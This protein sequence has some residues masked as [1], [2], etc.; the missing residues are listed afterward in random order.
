MLS[1][2][3]VNGWWS[4]GT[5]FGSFADFLEAMGNGVCVG[6]DLQRAP[7][8][9]LVLGEALAGSGSFGEKPARLAACF[10]PSRRDPGSSLAEDP[11]TQVSP[12]GLPGPPP[13]ASLGLIPLGSCMPQ[14]GPS[15]NHLGS[16]REKEEH[17]LTQ[18]LF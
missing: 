12:P 14:E 15:P 8:E 9:A 5:D 17:L 7:A 2:I 6:T 18:M 10:A 1:L 13:S 16:K 3:G 4:L 11:R